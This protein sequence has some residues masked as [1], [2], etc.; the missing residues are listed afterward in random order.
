M[1]KIYWLIVVAENAGSNR[2]SDED[3]KRSKEE[4]ECKPRSKFYSY[5]MLKTLLE[6]IFKKSYNM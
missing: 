1:N 3:F 6:G 5:T 2:T 4:T